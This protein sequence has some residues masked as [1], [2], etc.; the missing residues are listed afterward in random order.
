MPI[1]SA[2][3]AVF[4]AGDIAATAV[5]AGVGVVADLWNQGG[6]GAADETVAAGDA[7]AGATLGAGEAF[8]FLARLCL[9]GLGEASALAAG[10]SDVAAVAAGE[11]S[12]LECLRLPAGDASAFAAGDSEAAA[13]SAGEASFL[14]RLCLAAGDASA[15]AAGD[16]EA[17]ALSAGEA[18]FLECLCLAAGDASAPAAGDSAGAGDW[19]INEANESPVNA[20]IRQV[21]LFMT[22]NINDDGTVVT[23]LK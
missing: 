22:E 21:N 8:S 12:F 3:F 23:T 20:I 7:A 15:F 4:A 2:G 14:E 10:D 6:L 17:A 1:G 5:G 18:A 19:A 16:S 13:L 9:A 11:A